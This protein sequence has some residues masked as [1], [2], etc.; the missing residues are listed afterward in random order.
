MADT[1]I[2]QDPYR[3]NYK[4]DFDFI[5]PL[6]ARSLVNPDAEPVAVGWPAHN[7]T[8][9]LFTERNGAV[10]T[11]SCIDGVCT[12]CYNDNGR[13]HIVCHRH[14]LSPGML[15]VDFYE[16]LPDTIY[17][18]GKRL[19]SSPQVLNIEIV[20]G[21]G[22]CA[23][24][25]EA[26]IVLPY[27]MLRY[28]DLTEEEKA[29]LQSPAT[30]AAKIA[31]A[32]EL[33]RVAN[34]QYRY[35]NEEIRKTA[36]AQRQTNEGI[37]ENKVN[38]WQ[39]AEDERKL[40]EKRREDAEKN[41]ETQEGRRVTEEEYRVRAENVRKD[42]ETTRQIQETWRSNRFTELAGEMASASALIETWEGYINTWSTNENTARA[43]EVNRQKAEATRQSNELKREKAEA[44]R[45]EAE[46]KRESAEESRAGEFATWQDAIAAKQ[47]ALTTTEDLQISED[48]E[49]SLTDIG[50]RTA[51]D[52]MY[53][54]AVRT[55]GD[56]D[57][58]HYE[59][60]ESKPYKL[61]G[62]WLTYTEARE[63]LAR[64]GD[65]GW[66]INGLLHSAQ[67][68]RA[69]IPTNIPPRVLYQSQ[70]N[71]THHGYNNIRIFVC[72]GGPLISGNFHEFMS[73]CPNLE[74]IRNAR[75]NPTSATDWFKNCPKLREIRLDI[76]Q[77]ASFSLQ[78]CPLM[79]YETF[80][81]VT[82]EGSNYLPANSKVTITVH[83]D[84][85]AKLTGDTTNEAAAALTPEELAQWQQVL[86]DAVAKNISFA[87]L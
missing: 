50:K 12:N 8:A 69:N 19:E 11:A 18:D 47:D 84:V 13:I 24:T 3:V 29:E 71:I 78:W 14:G 22:D 10:F 38:L 49:L 85:Y 62:L 23:T 48:N 56:I 67:Y 34:E 20:R 83:P 55:Y 66:H 46:T 33:R 73:N 58:T 45:E 79:S 25:A 61:N 76:R 35:T 5:L 37:R 65:G 87:T 41:R 36:E 63:A 54:T 70:G 77:S 6:L 9:K 39:S 52:D 42:N 26:P 21:P 74:E 2:A 30:E 75:L 27:V 81:Y 64:Y 28:A 80:R 4:S 51:F 82:H 72:D 68:Q 17:P 32:G 57:Y 1:S 16:Q 53:R 44:D 59:D 31:E 86:A 40:A 15:H 60:G 7:W 43:N